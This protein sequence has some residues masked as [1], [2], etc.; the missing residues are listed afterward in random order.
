MKNIDYKNYKAPN[1][2]LTPSVWFVIAAFVM[3]ICI[4]SWLDNADRNRVKQSIAD[5]DKRIQQ[6]ESIIKSQ[7]N[8]HERS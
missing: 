4:V 8:G 7:V 3:A 2:L 1:H 5:R 6:L